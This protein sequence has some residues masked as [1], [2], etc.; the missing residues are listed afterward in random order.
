VRDHESAAKSDR[1][2][3]VEEFPAD[4]ERASTYV[5][6]VLADGDLAAVVAVEKVAPNEV[7]VYHNMAGHDVS[8][9]AAKVDELY[10]A[11]DEDVLTV[12]VGDGGNEVGMGNVART[13]RDEIQYGAECQCPCGKGIA[14]SVTVDVL[15]PAA[16]SNW[17]AYAVVAC[18]S[19]LLGESLLH[20]PAVERRMLER[21]SATGGVDGI[22]GRTNAWC[23]GMPPESHEAVVRLLNEVLSP[24]AHERGSERT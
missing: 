21:A 15:V 7:G 20:T 22:L 10:D 18:L 12:A 2:V 11:L 17:G 14:S 1:T 19:S 24:S 6:D 4:R 3:A 5:D 9:E 8:D 23:D 16:V 13:V